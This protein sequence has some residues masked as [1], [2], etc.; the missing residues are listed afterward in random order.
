MRSALLLPLVILLPAALE[1]QVG[2]SGPKPDPR[3]AAALDAI[4]IEPEIDADGDYKL[5]LKVDEDGGRTQ[6]VYVISSTERYGNLEIREV[7]APS[8]MR[9]LVASMA[10]ATSSSSR[11]P[12]LTPTSLLRRATTYPVATSTARAE[13]RP[14]AAVRATGATST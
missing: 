8:F 2:R 1:A 14:D 12:V 13:A 10:R 9:S 7:W 11:P 6:I 3:V 4:G 5:T